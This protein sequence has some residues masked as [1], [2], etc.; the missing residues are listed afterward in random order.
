MRKDKISSV[1]TGNPVD[2]PQRGISRKE[3]LAASTAVAMTVLAAPVVNA[4]GSA[5]STGNSK[6]QN[7]AI[8]TRYL[9]GLEVSALGL[10]CMSMAGVYNPPQPKEKMIPIIRTAVEQ[11]VTFFDTAEVYGPFLSEEIVGEALEPFKGKVVIAT[12]FGFGYNGNQTAG[13]DSRP[14]RIR[15]AVEGSLKRLRIETIDLCYLHRRDPNVPI[16]DVAG[17]VKDLI[18]EGKIRYFGLSEVSPETIRR[19]HAVQKVTAVQ[20]EYSMLERVMEKNIFPVCEELGIGFVPWGPTARGLLTDKYNNFSELDYRRAAI[21]YFQEQALEANQA[22]LAIVRDWAERKEA[23]P[24]QV[25]LAWIIAQK[26]WIVPIPGTTNPDH[27]LEN[28][29]ARGV[30]FT[31]AE[32]VEIRNSIEGVAVRGVRTPDQTL[33]D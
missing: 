18:Q 8:R 5:E 22:L 1:I 26:P 24:V 20:S 31:Q 4:R 17:T 19:A 11:G 16:E 10:G 30:H 32:L 29:G 33:R 13:L 3:F 28:I 14:E 6:E 12:K 21:P 23:T 25:A 9:G 27:S 2:T 7:T 15:Q